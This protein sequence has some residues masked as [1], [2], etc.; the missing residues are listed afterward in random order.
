MS[1]NE[2]R[3]SIVLSR[4]RQHTLTLD[5]A[6]RIL[7]LSSRHMKRIWKRFRQEGE[8]GLAHGN[9]GRPSNRAFSEEFKKEVL[10]RYRRD[11][12]GLGPTRFAG[13][14]GAQGI[15]IDHETLRR[16]LIENDL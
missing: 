7:A 14:L 1:E 5:Q 10:R 13:E 2:N 8:R 12:P 4:V 6:A 16:W 3:R 15:A 9:R 11:T